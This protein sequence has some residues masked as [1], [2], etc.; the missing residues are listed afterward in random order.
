LSE[1][2]DN[3]ESWRRRA[4]SC[5]QEA[6]ARQKISLEGEKMAVLCREFDIS[7]KT[8]YKLFARY[9]NCGLEGL[10]DRYR[11]PYRH[12]ICFR[13]ACREQGQAFA[14]VIQ[15]VVE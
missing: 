9:Q 11:R 7:R 5:G 6:R 15:P 13:R 3:A 8:G 12:A 2:A 4:R 1:S 14:P 10:N